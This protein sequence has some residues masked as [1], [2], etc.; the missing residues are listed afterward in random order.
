MLTGREGE[1]YR[2]A[3]EL[4]SDAEAAM[5]DA[6]AAAAAAAEAATRQPGDTR[7]FDGMEFVWIPAGDFRMGSTRGDE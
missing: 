7:E 2:A 6:E 4:L 3:L 1:H 5:A